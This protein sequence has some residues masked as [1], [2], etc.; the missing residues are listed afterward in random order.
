[1]RTQKA[2]K[3]M[4]VSVLLYSVLLIMGVLI[5]RILLDS[6]DTELV[7][8]D[9]LLTNLFSLLSI[10]DLGANGMFT[11]RMYEAFAKRDQKRINHLYNMYRVMFHTIGYVMSA[12]FLAVFL[13]LPVL[14]EGKVSH[15]G[16]FR[17]MFIISAA[18]ALITYFMGYWNTLLTCGQK[19]YKISAVQSTARI[20]M[21]VI[22]CIVLWT[23]KSYILYL[24][25]SLLSSVISQ[26]AIVILSR[27]EYPS[28][29]KEKVTL[30]DYQNEGI[31]QEIKQILLI[32]ICN[33]ISVSTDSLLITFLINIRTAAL[34]SNY[35][36][37]GT[38]VMEVFRRLAVP[39]RASIADMLYKEATEKS[40]RFYQTVKLAFWFVASTFFVCFVVVFQPAITLF[41]GGRFLLPMSFVFAYATYC[42]I[43]VKGES[44]TAFRE[45]YGEFEIEKK[46]SVIGMLLNITTSVLLS[47][48][49]GISGIIWGT[50]ISSVFL[51]NSRLL[52]V[53]KNLFKQSM[54]KSWLKEIAFFGLAL[55]E[56]LLVRLIT[57]EIP[58][59]WG[60]M[61][62]TG[63]LGV[64]ITNAVN[65]A[66]FFRTEAFQ[67]IIKRVKRLFIE[68]HK[69]EIKWQ[70]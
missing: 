16:Y 5:R 9:S 39:M 60:G 45:C 23:T 33:S 13:F 59:T 42:Y 64:M 7:G 63:T 49:I 1:M 14:F 26:V 3:N 17:L 70:R 66:L 24:G 61:L 19:E 68:W 29:H 54:V 56:L 31:F 21:L 6:F 30:K 22:K 41:F 51:W 67:D 57:R 12:V 46:Y 35:I 48:I 62:L 36:L 8:Y 10:A 43:G 65:V 58:Y 18:G 2:I 11:Y 20:A 50:V 44:A 15:W 38:N 37:I 52:I 27:K 28:I 32:K 34:Y 4:M 55:L 69:G 25:L 40:Y 47:K 53:D